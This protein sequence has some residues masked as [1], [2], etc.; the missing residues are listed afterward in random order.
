MTKKTGA[1][2][3]AL[4]ESANM[5]GSSFTS[6]ICLFNAVI[7]SDAWRGEFRRVIGATCPRLSAG[8]T[9]APETVPE[10]VALGKAARNER[11]KLA[12]LEGL[13]ARP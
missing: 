3:L 12:V 10:Q 4:N 7:K 8:Q 2:R 9:P 13:F 6:R 1:R 5:S 11:D